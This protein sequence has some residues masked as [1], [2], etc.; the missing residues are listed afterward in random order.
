MFNY[1]INEKSVSLSAIE[2]LN[3]FQINLKKEVYDNLIEEISN[4]MNVALED[5][6]RNEATYLDVWY[7]M[8]DRCVRRGCEHLVID[9]EDN[10]LTV[11]LIPYFDNHK[12]VKHTI[13][14]LLPK[15]ND[16]MKV[17]PI[18]YAVMHETL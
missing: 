8:F 4:K 7:K 9:F 3:F 18:E 15:E 2:V 14:S 1:T 5:K 11:Q 10:G 6:P 16:S 12:I 13:V 17:Q